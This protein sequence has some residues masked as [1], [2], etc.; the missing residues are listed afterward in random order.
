[1]SV[2][3]IIRSLMSVAVGRIGKAQTGRKRPFR[4]IVKT[5]KPLEE[6]I[7]NCDAQNVRSDES[8]R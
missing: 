7:R 8:I 3:L 2:Q 1:M 6:R 5:R 4:R